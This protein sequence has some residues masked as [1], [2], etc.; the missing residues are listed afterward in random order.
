[1]AFEEGV[2]TLT[3]KVGKLW[4]IFVSYGQPCDYLLVSKD[5]TR[6][7]KNDQIFLVNLYL[8]NTTHLGWKLCHKNK[9]FCKKLYTMSGASKTKI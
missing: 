3:P 7:W 8:A 4:D 2:D 9:T 5:G 1:M 6:I